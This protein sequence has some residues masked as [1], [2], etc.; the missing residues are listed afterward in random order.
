[1]NTSSK[2]K[3]RTTYIYPDTLFGS[4]EDVSGVSL[5]LKKQ[6]DSEDVSIMNK[7]LL[8]HMYKAECGLVHFTA[9]I[10]SQDFIYKEILRWGRMGMV[11]GE[12]EDCKILNPVDDYIIID[13]Y[14]RFKKSGDYKLFFEFYSYSGQVYT[15]TI[16]V[17]ITDDYR[18]SLKLY[19]IQT[20]PETELMDKDDVYN[21]LNINDLAFQLSSPRTY[22]SYSQHAQFFY[23]DADKYKE[24]VGLTHTVVVPVSTDYKVNGETLTDEYADQLVALT[25]NYWVYKTDR[26]FLRRDVPDGDTHTV[27]IFIKKTFN[28][29]DENIT[30]S[31]DLPEHKQRIVDEYRF[32]PIF[33]R[34]TEFDN[35]KPITSDT[36]IYIEPEIHHSKPISDC[37][38]VFDNRTTLKQFKSYLNTV[39][40]KHHQDYP[41]G[42]YMGDHGHN[43]IGGAQSVLFAAYHPNKLENGY[44]DVTLNYKEGET[45]QSISIKSAFLLKNDK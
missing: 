16:D 15:K 14:L 19:K 45:D 8:Q 3:A 5:E 2:I 34:L 38:W 39:H 43:R 31:S 1:M 42:R 7:Y 9:S 12:I 41:D 26:F 21:E 10:N 20:V 13:F 24:S 32:Y 27:L 36:V 28:P 29:D 18:N 6:E 23:V 11:E 22:K 35:T 37:N 40:D 4:K 44:Y 33:H 25:N 30:V 17:K